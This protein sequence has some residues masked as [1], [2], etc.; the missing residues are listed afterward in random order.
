MSLILFWKSGKSNYV[1]VLFLLM[2]SF[3][4]LMNWRS[5]WF[6]IMEWAKEVSF[7]LMRFEIRTLFSLSI[8]RVITL[9]LLFI[10]IRIWFW[11]FVC[12]SILCKIS[13][14]PLDLESCLNLIL[15]GFLVDWG[16]SLCWI[17]FSFDNNILVG[18]QYLSMTSILSSTWN[19]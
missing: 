17:I 5:I 18:W 1:D 6:L 11:I 12:E 9:F 16:D 7:F 2:N 8:R 14:I 4:E 19:K 13:F 15:K 10:G 3:L